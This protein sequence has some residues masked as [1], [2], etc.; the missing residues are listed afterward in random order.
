MTSLAALPGSTHPGSVS[1]ITSADELIAA[2]LLGYGETTRRGYLVDVRAWLGWLDSLGV[3]LLDAHRAHVDAWQLSLEEAGLAPATIARRLS[4]ISG[5][6]SYA[7]D[8]GLIARSP[9]TRVRR[10]TVSDDSPRLG[11]DRD[12]LRR[13]LEAAERSSARDLAMV[14]LL[15]LNGL[16]VSEA[17][18][19]RA[20][21]LGIERG[22]RVLRVTRKGGRRAMV[23]LAPRTAAAIDAMLAGRDTGPLFAT[24]TGR[25]VD[26]HAAWKVVKRLARQSGIT[27]SV[28]PHSFR[29]GFVTTALD[30]GVPLRDVQ[31]AAGHRDPRTTRRY[32]RG[33][34]SLDRHATYAVAAHL[35]G[36]H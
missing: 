28:S 19:A 7:L 8:E 17:L 2:W 13:L 36:G 4:A 31:D 1:P 3:E 29:H 5:L 27:H 9:L 34:H 26:R 23:P 20:E 6:Y 24:S 30:A 32:D 12:E 25:P 18:T 14:A 22:H 35:S 33:R 15:A 11:L 16:R 21:D 10:P